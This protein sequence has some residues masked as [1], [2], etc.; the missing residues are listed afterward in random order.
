M[1]ELMSDASLQVTKPATRLHSHPSVSDI[2]LLNYET[3]KVFGIPAF[4]VAGF[5]N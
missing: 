4:V 3:S 2:L 5:D 1:D